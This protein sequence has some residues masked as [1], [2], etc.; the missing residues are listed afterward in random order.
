MCVCAYTSGLLLGTWNI[1]K[2]AQPWNLL[3]F[4]SVTAP[5]KSY[6]LHL[7]VKW[8]EHFRFCALPIQLLFTLSIKITLLMKQSCEILCWHCSGFFFSSG[9]IDSAS[10]VQLR[11]LLKCITSV[12]C[13]GC[14]RVLHFSCSFSVQFIYCTF[15]L[16]SSLC[17]FPLL[18]WL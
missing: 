14:S 7:I 17:F 8:I 9:L 4:C 18:S 1:G 16:I 12:W 10:V 6:L 5:F 11:L 15:H 2:L 3:D 13:F